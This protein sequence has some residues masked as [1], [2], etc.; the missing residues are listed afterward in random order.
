MDTAEKA[1]FSHALEIARRFVAARQSATALSDYP[2]PL[3]PD[4]V[5]A[6]R[7]QDAAIDLWPDT[8]AGWKIGKIPEAAQAKVGSHRLAGPIFAKGVHKAADE[9]EIVCG[10]F[11]GGTACV[12]AEYVFEVGKD[13]PAD[14]TEW[15]IADAA[16]IAGRLFVGVEM[17]GSPLSDIN[18]RG[19]CIVVSDFG[20]NA[21]E[22]LGAEIPGWRALKWEDL[23]VETFIDGKLIGAGGALAI[24]GGPLESLQFIAE[25]VA[26]RG[27]PLKKGMLISTGAATGVHDVVAGQKARITFKGI[28][29]IRVAT[30]P[31]TAARQQQTQRT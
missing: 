28:Q 20:N 27:R 22:I 24:P 29:T 31:R 13:A 3:P 25:N 11:V 2:G 10:V 9:S 21:D 30:A 18:G 7:C 6:Y 17:A 4:L 12:E 14:K 1:K 16:K 15:S 19:P 23:T 8:V 5:S 26:K